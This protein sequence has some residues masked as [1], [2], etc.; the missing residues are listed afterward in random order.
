[1]AGPGAFVV[2]ARAAGLLWAVAFVV[3]GL[4]AD[5]QLYADGSIFSY[6]VADRASWA[7]HWHNIA[8]RATPHLLT[9]LPAEA[10]V[11][12]TGDGRAGIAIYGALFFGAP[13]AGLALT[14]V[15]DT[16]P[17]R[18]HFTFACLSTALLAPL[19]FGFPTELWLSLALFGPVM[20]SLHAI[21]PWPWPLPLA[22]LLALAFTHEG[23]VLLA[24]VAVGLLALRGLADAGF[25]RA[26]LLLAITMAA[27]MAVK[28]LLPP[29]AY[30]ASAYSRS[31]VGFLDLAALVSPVM[32]LLYS[33]A[34]AFVAL[35][36]G[37]ARAGS[38]HPATVA[39]IMAAA[40]LT[41]CWLLIDVPVHAAERYTVRTVMLGA[42]VVLAVAAALLVSASGPWR[43]KLVSHETLRPL[44]TPAM[45]ALVL[46]TLVH[47]VETAR[48]V[49][50]WSGYEKA[51]R[52]LAMSET[53]DPRLGDPRFADAERLGQHLNQLSWY[54]TTHFLSILLAPDWLPKRLVV[55]PDAGYYWFDCAMAKAD[56]VRPSAIPQESRRLVRVLSCRH[57]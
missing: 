46:V 11:A 3:V 9:H 32:L 12:L 53:S 5:L 10:Y 38:R 36:V 4:A 47:A 14:W 31:A 13:L 28:V 1:M 35:S 37:L 54:S 2:V 33:A 42:A 18:I 39:A 55:D 20:A 21:R 15:L 51:V 48:F 43:T 50:A 17:T 16:T 40:G 27:W 6:A 49:V 57:R 26:L 8:Q 52:D 24:V 56:E 7:V 23:G 22:L 29:D 34:A 25:H 44:A 41:A 30:F 19:V 45:L